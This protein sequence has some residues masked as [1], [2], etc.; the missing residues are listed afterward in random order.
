MVPI[1]LPQDKPSEDDK[2]VEAYFANEH[3]KTR[4]HRL[5]IRR[6]L[7][8][9]HYIGMEDTERRDIDQVVQR[10]TLKGMKDLGSFTNDKAL[11]KSKLIMVD[12]LW[13]WVL[14]KG[15]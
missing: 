1:G 9:S 10:Y 5:H 4:G 13:M 15:S 8:Q 6:T 12:Q 3:V 14:G 7:D 11:L 2:L